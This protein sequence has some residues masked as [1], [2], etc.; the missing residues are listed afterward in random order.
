M[1][2]SQHV[3]APEDHHHHRH[4]G[5]HDGQHDGNHEGHHVHAPQDHHNHHRHVMDGSHHVDV[6]QDTHTRTDKHTPQAPVARTKIHPTPVQCPL[7]AALVVAQACE[8]GWAL[9]QENVQTQV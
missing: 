2:G 8:H 4:F 7:R 5:H 9:L 3:D 1:D 6:T